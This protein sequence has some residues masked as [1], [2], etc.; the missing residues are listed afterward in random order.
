RNTSRGNTT[1]H[2]HGTPPVTPT[3]GTAISTP[4]AVPPSASNA[5]RPVAD[6]LPRNADRVPSTSQNAH[7]TA[8]ERATNTATATPRPVRTL[9]RNQIDEGVSSSR[10]GFHTP[11]RLSSGADPVVGT[12]ALASA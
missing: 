2:N 4:S 3:N 8:S 1:H 9:L 11:R 7:G 6:T 5:L 12:P 10:S